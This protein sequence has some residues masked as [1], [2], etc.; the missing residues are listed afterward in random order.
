MRSDPRTKSGRLSNGD[1][2]VTRERKERERCAAKSRQSAIDGRRSEITNA[3]EEESSSLAGSDSHDPPERGREGGRGDE[4]AHGR[5]NGGD[6]LFIFFLQKKPL[7]KYKK[8]R[9]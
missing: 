5:F 6:V 9:G 2:R 7:Y 4:E 1:R 3:E 8:M